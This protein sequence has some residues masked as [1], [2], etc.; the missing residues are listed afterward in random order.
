MS[1]SAAC[2]Q[3]T[4]P[5]TGRSGSH[6]TR[7][8]VVMIADAWSWVRDSEHHAVDGD[9]GQLR[10]RPQRSDGPSLL[11]CC[12]FWRWPAVAAWRRRAG[13]FND[14]PERD[15]GVASSPS[16]IET[17]RD[18]RSTARR[19][20]AERRSGRLPAGL[21]DTASCTSRCRRLADNAVSMGGEIQLSGYAHCLSSHPVH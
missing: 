2:Q 8:R 4:S 14:D 7:Y 3:E 9:S 15:P 12:C 6:S 11:V 10:S 16:R 17:V 19:G 5:S 21:Y 1:A 18:R 13:S 20:G